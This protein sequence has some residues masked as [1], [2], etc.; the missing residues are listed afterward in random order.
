MPNWYWKQE[1]HCPSSGIAARHWQ[2]AP[3][4]R[5]IFDVISFYAKPAYGVANGSTDPRN[6]P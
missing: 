3:V 4:K 2:R 1:R 6:D 5:K